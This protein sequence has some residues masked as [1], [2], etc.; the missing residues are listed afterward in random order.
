MSSPLIQTNE[1]PPTTGGSHSLG[2]RVEV[3]REG[4]P[5]VGP[6]FL[7]CPQLEAVLDLLQ[8]QLFV[9]QTEDLLSQ[10]PLLG[11]Q[12]GPPLPLPDLPGRLHVEVGGGGAEDETL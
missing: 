5:G 8:L 3:R 9:V 2:V 7:L 1:I 10:L 4:G 6:E 11:A 12:R